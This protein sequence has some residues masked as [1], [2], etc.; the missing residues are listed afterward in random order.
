MTR[1]VVYGKPNCGLCEGAKDKLK[2]MDL[3]YTVR[4]IEHLM[5]YW[6][7]EA[8]NRAEV[9]AVQ[10]EY[11]LIDTLPVLV[12]DGEAM[13]YPRAMKRLKEK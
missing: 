7:E 2:R 1:I 5:Q 13:S 10:A 6:E 4:N 11:A 12:V 9:V 8:N 3:D